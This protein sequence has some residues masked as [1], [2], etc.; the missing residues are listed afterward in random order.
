MNTHFGMTSQ[1]I[2]DRL[3]LMRAQVIT[4]DMHG[5]LLGLACEEIFQKRD[6]LCAGVAGASLANHLAAGGMER[7]VQ[8]ERAVAIILKAVSFGPARGR[9]AEPDPTGPALG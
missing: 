4:D 7:R 6:E 9:V 3:G 1:K 8:R 5:L 2:T